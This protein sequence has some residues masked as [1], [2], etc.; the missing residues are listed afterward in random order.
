MN[1]MYKGLFMCVVF[2]HNGRALFGQPHRGG[3]HSEEQT[4]HV[5]VF[6]DRTD[7]R[8][9]PDDYLYKRYRFSCEGM[10]GIVQTTGAQDNITPQP[11]LMVGVALLILRVACSCMEMQNI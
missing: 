4:F 1:W 8:T 3:T 5:R 7:P 10:C 6:W 2:L 9:F 11:S